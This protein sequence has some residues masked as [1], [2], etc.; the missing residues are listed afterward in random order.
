MQRRKTLAILSIA[1]SLAVLLTF[2][3]TPA[4]AD[5]AASPRLRY[6]NQCVTIDGHDLVLYSGA[7][8]YFRCPKPLW[9]DRF[10]KLKEAGF[11][12]LETYAAWNWHEP[13]PPANPDDFSNLDMTD[14]H[15]W[16]AMAIDQFGF[17][18]YLRPGPYIC[19][20]WDGGGYPQWLLNQRPKDFKGEW[21]RSDEPTYLAWSKH[22]YTAV[23]KT[24]VPFQITHRS[25]DKPGGLI[26]WQI[27]NEYDYDKLPVEVKRKQLDFLAHTSRDLGIDVPLTTCLTDNPAFRADEYLKENVVETRNTYPKFSM[28]NMLRDIGM[29]ERYQPE[30]FRMI[31]ELQGGWFAQVGGQ[32]SEAQG[33]DATHIN[34]VALFAWEHGFT[35]TNFY[36][37]FGGTNFG[38]WA[39]AGLTT[40]YDYDAPVREC[41]G[42]T[43]RYLAVKALGNFITEHGPRLARSTPETFEITLK[44]E[45]DVVVSLRRAADGSRYLFVR[46]EQRRQSKRG[47]VE[48]QTSGADAA[49]ITAKYDLGP[50]G[51]KV[52]YLPPGASND[53]SDGGGQWYPKP[54]DPPQPPTQL[55][56]P[57]VIAEA[58]TQVDAGPTSDWH[59]IQPGQSLESAGVFNRGYVFYRATVPAA[60]S[61]DEHLALSSHPR[62]RDWAGFAV[63]GQRLKSDAH[64]GALLIAPSSSGATLLGLFD[65]G[66]RPNFGAD[67]DRPSGLLDMKISTASAAPRQI[68]DWR[69]KRTQPTKQPAEAT[70]SVDDSSWSRARINVKDGD[71]QPGESAMYRA[72]VELNDD[73]LK[74]PKSLT[75]GRVDEDGVVWVNGQRVGEAHDWATAQ[76]F[77]VA[78]YLR[79]GKNLIAVLVTNH[80][81][82]GGLA[83]GAWLGSDGPA[84]PVR[85]EISQ[86]SAG[87]TGKWA[88]ESF[89]DSAWPT[90]KVDS[91]SATTN[92]DEPL[93]TWYRLRFELPTPDA[94]AW[95][96]WKLRLDAVG[97]G[98]L[99][100]NGHPLGRWWQVGP[101]RDFFLPECWMHFGP[102]ATNVLTIAM[103]PT[104][105]VGVKHAEVGPYENMAEVRS[106]LP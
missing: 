20:E 87:T 94:H 81:G 30:K 35:S 80:D 91:S 82:P 72:W 59:A 88:D 69:E 36:M 55:P 33:F 9:P 38:D 77:D 61:G 27:E 47:S 1:L 50:Y 44:P 95:V 103:H 89:D 25:A 86:Q 42:V 46:N 48:V 12:M 58:R 13:Q 29:L 18:V 68:N 8:H 19:A 63:N 79:P 14:L 97:N 49:K 74:T 51:S 22:W 93:L 23:A 11:N 10:R 54:V 65:N 41:G 28:T 31:S 43:E 101:Q 17:Y 15:D 4:R 5:T 60:P 64:S 76:H 96:P 53:G 24:A 3:T 39:A 102:G 92:G 105:G 6:D 67:I 56:K 71:L 21:L 75:L 104:D 45:A 100:L 85:W 62:G 32:L 26:L 78:Q 98:F 7:F 83:G 57:I 37:G 40:T 73:D 2:T 16:L 52:L 84:L 106:L 70:A 34:H 99:Y 66:G 90:A